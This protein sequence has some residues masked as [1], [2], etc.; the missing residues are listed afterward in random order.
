MYIID[1]C[2][3]NSHNY[4][5]PNNVKNKTNFVGKLQAKPQYDKIS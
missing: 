1:I 4:M 2:K 3:G 5:L